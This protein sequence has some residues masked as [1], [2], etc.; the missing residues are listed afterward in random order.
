MTMI[1]QVRTT[2]F[3]IGEGHVDLF[4]STK[5]IDKHK[6]KVNKTEKTTAKLTMVVVIYHGWMVG[7]ESNG[8]VF[9]IHPPSIPRSVWILVHSYPSVSIPRKCE[10]YSPPSRLRALKIVE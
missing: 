10:S 3:L 5:K 7:S 4:Y 2:R 9:P 8:K 6:Q 1:R